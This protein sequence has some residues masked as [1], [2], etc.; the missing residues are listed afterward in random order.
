MVS[1]Q[2]HYNVFQL[3]RLL[4]LL[5][6]DFTSF[7]FRV[8]ARLDTFDSANVYHYALAFEPDFLLEQ[9]GTLKFGWPF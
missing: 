9:H 8:I 5:F 6:V 7:L 3:C 1:T 2:S 4:C